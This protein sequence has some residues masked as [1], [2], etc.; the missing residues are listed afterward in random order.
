MSEGYAT[1]TTLVNAESNVYDRGLDAAIGLSVLT[2]A[3]GM[4]TLVDAVPLSASGAA[5]GESLGLILAVVVGGVGIVGVSSWANVTPV[6]SQRVRG[7]ALGLVVSTLGL[8]VLAYAVP[9]TLATLLGLTLVVEAVAVAVAGVAS[10]VET[11]DTSP[12]TSAGL[13]AGVVFGALGLTLG[14][15]IGGSLVG[16]DSPAWVAVALG[17]G[18]VLSALTVLPREDVGSTIPAALVVGTLGLTIATAVVGVGWQWNPQSLSG[19][20][21]GGAVI[22]IFVL[23]GAILS[24][25]SAAKCRAGFGARGREFGAFL[26]INLNVFLMVAV[27]ATIV[28]FVTVKGV[29]YALHG[30]TIGA[31]SALVLL[32]PL[33][34]VVVNAARTPAGTDDWHTGARQL[35]RLLPLAAVGSV[36]AVLLSVLVTGDRLA[37]PFTYSVQVN[38]AQ[39][40][41]DTAIA[42]TPEPTVGSLLLVAPALLLSVYFFRT[43][44][45][46]RNVGSR[47]GWAETIRQTLPLAVAG[48]VALTGLFLLVGPRPLGLP[49][50]GTLGVA[51]VVLAAV[52]A[53]VLAALPLAG[54]LAGEGTLADRAQDRATLFTLG[55]FGSLALL[56]SALFLQATATVTPSVGPVNV[57]PGVALAGAVAASAATALVAYAKRQ[58]GE[59]LQRRLLGEEIALGLT[60]VA[61]FLTLLGLHVAVTKV[62][63]TVLGV[64][65][66]NAGTLSWP[67]TMQTYIPLGTEPG[68]ILPAVVGTVWLVTGATLFAVPLGVGA[69]VFLTEYA[70]QGRFTALVEIATNALWSTPSI[71][72]GLFGAAF[73]IPRLGGDES[74]LAGMLVLGFMLLPLVLIT[75]REAVKSVPDEYRDASAALGVSQWETIKSVVLPAAMPGVITGVILGVGR[76]AGETAPLILVLGSTL[77]ATES[78]QVLD[79]FRFTAQPPFV[80]NDALLSASASL[81]TQVWAVIAAGVSGSPS[82]GWASAFVL[83]LVVLTFYAVGITARTYFRRKLTHE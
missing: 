18:L 2:F 75:S 46:L 79:G 11:V 15:A 38:R 83:L 20:F 43:Y 9:V 27:M 69:A 29:G 51:V 30:F 78:A 42:V 34:V 63:F 21:T 39:Q 50:G 19:G 17:A 71:V 22:P 23:V 64:S 67:M 8:T 3:L 65:V 37:Y 10:R 47:V 80:A 45:S 4:V 6:E 26:V 16:F 1:E 7:I 41:L 5:L 76:I 12:N 56:T 60:G 33:L 73:L 74:L 66:A 14:A 55:V 35:F 32:A 36:A 52:A 54:V 58:S 44:G 59:T 81:P 62:S 53:V 25:W 28:V 24:S 49:L 57:V 31:L 40:S 61:G 13:L 77:N 68:G 82:M 72:F 48:T 70:E